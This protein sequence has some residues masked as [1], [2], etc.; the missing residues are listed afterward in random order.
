MRPTPD[1]QLDWMMKRGWNTDSFLIDEVFD[2]KR[3]ELLGHER[4]TL[5]MEADA[6]GDVA[7][8]GATRESIFD[9]L[10]FLKERCAD[11]K[12]FEYLD[13][14]MAVLQYHNDPIYVTSRGAWTGET[15]H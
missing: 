14:L 12:S 11:R 6:V 2:Y 1:E 13:Q 8:S 5:M 15:I 10:L 4:V 9:M 7:N 3:S